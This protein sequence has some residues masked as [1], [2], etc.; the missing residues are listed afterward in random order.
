MASGPGGDLRNTVWGGSLGQVASLIPFLLT[1]SPRRGPWF[2]CLG[3]ARFSLRLSGNGMSG[4][5]FHWSQGDIGQ[6]TA[7]CGSQFCLLVN[8]GLELEVL[9]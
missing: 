4:H 5:G 1:E 9:G 7:L 8:E 2:V 3:M 6:V